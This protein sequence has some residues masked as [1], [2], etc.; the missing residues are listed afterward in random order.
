MRSHSR[1][2]AASLVCAAALM[3]ACTADDSSSS[4]GPFRDGPFNVPPR[5]GWGTPAIQGE[6]FTDGLE[7]LEVSA[8]VRV[9]GIRIEGDDE[10]ELVGAL[11]VPRVQQGTI[12]QYY[13]HYPPIKQPDAVE[14]VGA[15]V[16][17]AKPGL[18][19]LLG[20]KVDEPGTFRRTAI[21]IRYSWEG[22]EREVRI[23][24]E[25]VVCGYALGEPA[26]ECSG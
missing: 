6:A 2:M 26:P 5:H 21:I 22:N 17:P 19:L 4:D 13:P 7:V 11:Y 24:A 10:I 18:E 15:T 1:R 9:E 23:P 14:I 12:Q 3:T 25:L 8:P 20:F 16:E